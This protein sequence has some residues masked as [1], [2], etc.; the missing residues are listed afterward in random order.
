MIK[1]SNGQVCMTVMVSGIA[2][3]SRRWWSFRQLL[4]WLGGVP[5]YEVRLIDLATK[6]SWFQALSKHPFATNKAQM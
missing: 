1:S 6:P 2:G 4:R 5:F 3:C